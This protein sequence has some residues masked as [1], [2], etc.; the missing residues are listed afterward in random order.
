MTYENIKS[1]ILS[2]LVITSII[3]TWTLWTYQP[4]FDV[5]EESDK[6]V[7]EVSLGEKKTLADV[8]R[9][10]RLFYHQEGSHFGTFDTFEI[11][12]TLKE[13]SRWNYS[14][15]EDISSTVKN[16]PSFLYEKKSVEL[17]FPD[18]VPL[19]LL[20]STLKLADKNLPEMYMDRL[21]VDLNT[22][23]ELGT[24]YFISTK[25]KLVI[26]AR[27]PATFIK[28]YQAE[29]VSTVTQNGKFNSYTLV[30]AEQFLLVRQEP[31]NL[32]MYNYLVEE[33]SSEK[34]R[35]ALFS[36]PR[37]V[38]KNFS[39]FGEEYT[40]SST[41]MSI[42]YDSNTVFYVKTA[43]ETEVD[44][45]I[46]DLLEQS[47]EFVNSHGGWTDNYR[48]AGIDVSERYILYRLYDLSGY[49]IYSENRTSEIYQIWGS[50]EV[51]KYFRS[52]F[53]LGRRVQATEMTLPSGMEVLEQ[54]KGIDGFQLENIQDLSIA[55]R[56]TKD[57][58]PLLIHLEP[59][60]YVKY[61]DQWLNVSQMLNKEEK[62]GLE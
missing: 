32:A 16:V 41:L 59:T 55:Y 49:P 30:N 26:R 1:A 23:N 58:E 38:Q 48:F 15:F 36:D 11:D 39:T 24:V 3:L 34:F 14:N 40:D 28:A 52:N 22:P 47:L 18:I 25:E 61:N 56:M 5:M 13:M 43:E 20:K 21:V 57:D 8:V 17:I 51:N 31:I 62:Y 45:P 2:I 42:N 37:F 12:Q 35:D 50:S 19:N 6:T 44:E 7:E 4:N 60:W 29:H 53:T 10:E 9:P 27:V 54:L 46:E 33:L